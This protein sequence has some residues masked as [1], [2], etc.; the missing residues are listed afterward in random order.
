MYEPVKLARDVSG[1][2]FLEVHQDVVN[3]H[4]VDINEVHARVDAAGLSSAVDIARV[5]EVFVR[6]WGTREDMTRRDVTTPATDAL[7][8][9]PI[10]PTHG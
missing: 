4:H 5:A 2:V 9:P 6:A 7:I 8:A 3:G 10:Q 1:N